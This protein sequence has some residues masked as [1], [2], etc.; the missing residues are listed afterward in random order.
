MRLL[1]YDPA[2]GQ[3]DPGASL[4]V[5]KDTL[6]AA[7]V[8]ACAI[9]AKLEPEDEL[10]QLFHTLSALSP[11]APATGLIRWARNPRLLD[12]HEQV[13][14]GADM[15]WSGDAMRRDADKR[16]P[17]ILFHMDAPDTALLAQRA[18]T[19]LWGAS[20]QVPERH[21]L[22]RTGAKLRAPMSRPPMPLSR[23]CGRM[24]RAGRWS[25]TRPVR[26]GGRP[27]H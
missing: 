25:A 11:N 6:A 2:I 18:F 17:L 10:R 1:Q 12:A 15:C 26:P 8:Q 3:F 14:Y 5:M 22:A 20:V 27:R 4:I 19:A 23:R 16:N 24:S 9:L 21:L 7:G 13:T